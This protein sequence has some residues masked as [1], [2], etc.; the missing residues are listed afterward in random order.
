MLW[1]KDHPNKLYSY[2]PEFH[3]SATFVPVDAD[4]IEKENQLESKKRWKTLDGWNYPGVKTSLQSNEHP[5]K[6]DQASLD[7]LNEVFN[8]LE[9]CGL[10][11]V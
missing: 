10:L 2:N 3:H 9:I 6:L 7:K 1:F 5:R 11:F 8:E 4:E